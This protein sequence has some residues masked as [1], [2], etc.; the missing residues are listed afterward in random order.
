[1]PLE[2]SAGRYLIRSLLCTATSAN[3]CEPIFKRNRKSDFGTF[4]P[5]WI[6]TPG[7]ALSKKNIHLYKYNPLVKEMSSTATRVT[8]MCASKKDGKK[9]HPFK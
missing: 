9:W 8:L 1:M 4:L 7:K 3:P 2:G 6:L 5:S